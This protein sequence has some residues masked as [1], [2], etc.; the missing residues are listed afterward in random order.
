MQ[1]NGVL[2]A[3]VVVVR[4][5]SEGFGLEKGTFRTVTWTRT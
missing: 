5:R 1:G 3:W 4:W 2:G